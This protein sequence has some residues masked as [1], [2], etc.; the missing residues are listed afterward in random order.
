MMTEAH[1]KARTKNVFFYRSWNQ[2]LGKAYYTQA[3]WI[4]LCENRT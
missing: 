4:G 3:E 2:K 1:H